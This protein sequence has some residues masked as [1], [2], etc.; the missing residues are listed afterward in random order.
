MAESRKSTQER[1]KALSLWHIA[2][3][4]PNM[5]ALSL[6]NLADNSTG[7][8]RLQK[9]KEMCGSRHTSLLIN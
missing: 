9:I 7:E 1:L 8:A 3:A 4:I 5:G 2:N 6:L